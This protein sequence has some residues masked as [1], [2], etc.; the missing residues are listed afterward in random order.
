MTGQSRFILGKAFS[1]LV[2]DIDNRG[3]CG[4]V[5]VRGISEIF[6]SVLQFCFKLALNSKALIKSSFFKSKKW[7]VLNELI[8]EGK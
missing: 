8:E 1:I 3:G 5:G 7:K 6:E 4:Y 2:N